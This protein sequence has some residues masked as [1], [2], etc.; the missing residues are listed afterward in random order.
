MKLTF[1][2]SATVAAPLRFVDRRASWGRH[3]F[4]IKYGV[5]EH[6][7]GGL[8]LVDTGYANAIMTSRDPHVIGYR[9]LL[10]PRLNAQEEAKAVVKAKGAS[11]RDVRHILLS[12]LHADHV[13]GLEHFPN[14]R[15]YA[16]GASL[17]GWK[18]PKS[19]VAFHKGFF[20]SLLPRFDERVVGAIE[21]ASRHLL[22]WGGTGFDVLND[23][24]IIAVDLPGHMK[25]HI[26]FY[27]PK[28]NEPVLYAADADWTHEGLEDEGSP[29]WPARLIVDDV[30]ALLASKKTVAKARSSGV[31]IVLSHDDEK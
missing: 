2:T 27:F 26:G 13:C 30:S 3:L 22:P 4:P 11:P 9:S 18:K 29:P 6:P 28:L 23:G 20:S 25:G 5:L 14:A 19:F 8:I 1:H 15:I 31:G 12:H 21:N 10:R 7:E 17:M 16:S 24:S